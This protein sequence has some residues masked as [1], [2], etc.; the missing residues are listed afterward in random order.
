[1]PNGLNVK[2]ADVAIEIPAT[3]PASGLDMF[4]CSPVLVRQ[5][6]RRIAQ[7]ESQLVIDGATYQR[8][9]RHRSPATPWNA[10]SDN[11]IT[12]MALVEASLTIE[13]L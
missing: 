13:G 5:D 4:Y 11:L 8:W 6:G 2:A 7:T 3:Y 1:M 12:H 10:D 9:S